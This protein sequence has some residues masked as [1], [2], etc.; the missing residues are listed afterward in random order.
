MRCNPNNCQ[1][2]KI[3][4]MWIVGAALLCNDRIAGSRSACSAR[5]AVSIIGCSV[6]STCTASAPSAVLSPATNVAA[7]MCSTPTPSALGLVAGSP[8]R[9]GGLDPAASNFGHAKTTIAATCNQHHISGPKE[10]LLPCRGRYPGANARK[11]F[12]VVSTPASPQYNLGPDGCLH[13]AAAFAF[14]Q[15]GEARRDAGSECPPPPPLSP[16]L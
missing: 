11:C 5:R 9:G 2:T 4:R 16:L 8:E 14:M 15:G 7:A 12:S 3:I 6:A 13:L 1:R 10:P